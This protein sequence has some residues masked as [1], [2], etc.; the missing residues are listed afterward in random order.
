[1]SDRSKMIRTAAALPVG[2]AERRRIL[3]D[4]TL[5]SRAIRLASSM[6]AGSSAR[7]ELLRV[8]EAA[9]KADKAPVSKLESLAKDN[10]LK[11]DDLLDLTSFLLGSPTLTGQ[12]M[13]VLVGNFKS[14]WGGSFPLPWRDMS[15]KDLEDTVDS[16]IKVIP[17]AI[18]MA[19][20]IKEDGGNSDG[21]KSDEGKS[22]KKASMIRSASGMV[23][24]MAATVA[25]AHRAQEDEKRKKEHQERRRKEKADQ[26][27]KYKPSPG[28]SRNMVWSAKEQ[29]PVDMTGKNY[30]EVQDFQYDEYK[31]ACDQLDEEPVSKADWGKV[32]T[33]SPVEYQRRTNHGY[34]IREEA[35]M[36]TMEDFYRNRELSN[37]VGREIKEGKTGDDLKD[38]V[39]QSMNTIMK[40][41]R[42]DYRHMRDHVVKEQIDKHM[43]DTFQKIIKEEKATAG[44]FEKLLGAIAPGWAAGK[45]EGRAKARFEKEKA[46]GKRT[47]EEYLENRRS[48]A[49]PMAKEEWE[50]RFGK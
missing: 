33:F 23:V 1:M 37:I 31:W 8:I 48:D 17:Y 47:Y 5:R 27:A 19:T 6:P 3:S 10:G 38:S 9:D 14:W 29:T 7:A 34:Y 39:K 40:R 20:A 32:Q 42:E 13:K 30:Q 43:R 22:D 45:A 16:A 26:D 41:E 46:E 35:D 4:L 18:G 2:D 25:A 44:V 28:P 21:G 24:M 49:P 50:A 15:K 11:S 36:K 12:P